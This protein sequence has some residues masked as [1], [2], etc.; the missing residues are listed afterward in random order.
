MRWLV[1]CAC[2][3]N[4]Q[5]PIAAQVLAAL[6]C[7]E[8]PS[9]ET[10]PTALQS[11]RALL[12]PVPRPPPISVTNQMLSHLPEDWT[13]CQLHLLQCP[14]PISNQILVIVR[15]QRSHK[16]ILALI[17]ILTEEGTSDQVLALVMHK[18]YDITIP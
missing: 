1:L 8:G 15:A 3:T 7:E 17:P 9:S 13:L 18:H 4:S 6:T 11:A 10:K 5:L 2:R 12:Y 16:P 14:A